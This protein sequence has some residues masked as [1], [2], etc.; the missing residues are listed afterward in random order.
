MEIFFATLASFVF[1]F[2]KAFQ[3]RNVTGLHYRPV[4]PISILMAATEVYVIA[5]VVRVGYDPALVLGVGCGAGTGAM[6]AMYLHNYI[7]R[8]D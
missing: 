8:R 1:V 4:V 2:L 5:T 6:A 7:F 3:Q